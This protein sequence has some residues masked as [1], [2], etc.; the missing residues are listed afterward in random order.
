MSDCI[1][2]NEE[3]KGFIDL[4][5]KAANLRLKKVKSE[6]EFLEL[7][8]KKHSHEECLE[9]EKRRRNLLHELELEGAEIEA[10]Y[11]EKYR[12]KILDISV[13]HPGQF[14]IFGKCIICSE[15]ITTTCLD[16]TACSSCVAISSI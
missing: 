12:S 3:R 10:E 13:D 7:M 5:L 14:Q 4:Q 15:C 2:S 1:L 6:R 8:G 11:I 9:I 16:C